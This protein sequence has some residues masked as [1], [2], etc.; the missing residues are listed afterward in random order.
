MVDRAFDFGLGQVPCFGQ[1]HGKRYS[2]QAEASQALEHWGLLSSTCAPLP[3]VRM[4][5][6]KLLES[7]GTQAQKTSHLS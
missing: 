2:V 7:P 1:W 3:P 6:E 4:C 5:P